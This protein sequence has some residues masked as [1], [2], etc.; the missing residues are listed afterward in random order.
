MPPEW[1]N[2]G[3]WSPCSESCGEGVR[4]RSRTCEKDPD[5]P[6]DDDCDG[7]DEETEKCV[8]NAPGKS[9]KLKY[10]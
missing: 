7:G 5:C 10:T 9:I 4:S 6:N 2:W 1:S 8:E 3:E